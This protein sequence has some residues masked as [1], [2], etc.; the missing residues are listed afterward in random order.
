[1]R[2]FAQC[3]PSFLRSSPC[4]L[5]M[6]TPP[7]STAALCKCYSN[8]QSILAGY[9][10]KSGL[11]SACAFPSPS[12]PLSPPISIRNRSPPIG[13]PPPPTAC[14]TVCQEN[15]GYLAGG[16]LGVVSSSE[17]SLAD[18]ILFCNTKEDV[19]YYSF[20]VLFSSESPERGA[21]T[22]NPT[23]HP[24]IAQRNAAG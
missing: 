23:L 4:S 17:T 14:P 22:P 16:S 1:M 11:L 13:P 9:G 5:A 6:L 10:I 3:L 24:A 20:S 15:V 8:C 12:P 19:Q 7:L 21:Q 18:C 2:P